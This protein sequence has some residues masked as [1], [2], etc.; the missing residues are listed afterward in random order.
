MT[1]ITTH[2]AKIVAQILE[3]RGKKQDGRY[4][5]YFES[6]VRAVEHVIDNLEQD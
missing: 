5:P 4:Q 2:Y 3:E 1:Q 6:L